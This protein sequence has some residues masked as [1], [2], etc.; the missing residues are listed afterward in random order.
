MGRSVVEFNIC[1]AFCGNTKDVDIFG[2]LK[3]QIKIAS[4]LASRTEHFPPI[5]SSC[6]CVEGC[7]QSRVLS[8][9]P[10]LHS[11]FTMEEQGNSFIWVEPMFPVPGFNS[12]SC[13]TFSCHVSL[14][15]FNLKPLLSLTWFYFDIFEYK[16]C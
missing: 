16:P 15:T 12:G 7:H 8:F 10:R 1:R 4:C 3:M 9:L 2:R 5:Y 11:L 6:F 14:I 13:I